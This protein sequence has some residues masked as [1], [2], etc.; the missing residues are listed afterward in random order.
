MP[1]SSKDVASTARRVSFATF[2]E[3]ARR[4]CYATEACNISRSG[5]ASQ[6]PACLPANDTNR[7]PYSNGTYST[8]RATR[9]AR[10][11]AHGPSTSNAPHRH[12]AGSPDTTANRRPHTRQRLR[13][14]SPKQLRHTAWYALPRVDSTW[15]HHTNHRSRPR[16]RSPRS[17]SLRTMWALRTLWTLWAW[18]ARI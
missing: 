1:N 7:D 11:G 5:Y 13:R 6:E 16:H 9:N 14:G 15:R 8:W 12:H 18:N 2:A 10:P 4:G 17:W 3:H